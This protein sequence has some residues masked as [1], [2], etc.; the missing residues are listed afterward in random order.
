[1]HVVSV[2]QLQSR[3]GNAAGEAVEIH[4]I[5][6]ANNSVWM[7]AQGAMENARSDVPRSYLPAPF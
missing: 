6:F 5:I 1:M 4:R 2:A 7:P 3:T